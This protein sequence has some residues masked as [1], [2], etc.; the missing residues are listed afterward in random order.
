M[1]AIDKVLSEK[2]KAPSL[3]KGAYPEVLEIL[4]LCECRILF[5]NTQLCKWVEGDFNLWF[6]ETHKDL[7][8]DISN[9]HVREAIEDVFSMIET[10]EE[11]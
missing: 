11:E 6:M 3:G 4:I 1:R 10:D 8:K 5:G 2:E 9:L 7:L